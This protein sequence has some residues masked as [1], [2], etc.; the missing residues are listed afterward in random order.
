[1]LLLTVLWTALT[2]LDAPYPS[3]LKLQHAPTPFAIAALAW[4]HN[5]GHLSQV[6]I[7]CLLGFLWLHIFGAR[8]LYSMV[9]YDQW[10]SELFGSSIS[11]TM[12]WNRN[13]YDRLVHLASGLLFTPPLFEYSRR[14]AKAS[15][16]H[17]AA[18]AFAWVLAI[19]AIYEV[20]EWQLAVNMS[21]HM[22]ESY[23]GQQGDVWDAQKDLALAAIG[24]LFS[25][26]TISLSSYIG[27]APIVPTKRST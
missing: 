24:S 15:F 13:H 17:S 2:F 1:M 26:L 11:S 7:Y 5:R 21:P 3:E 20:F 12:G 27:S 6:G 4:L 10:S 23:N 9:P 14:N 25:I 16:T 8:W 19:G 18:N 22:A